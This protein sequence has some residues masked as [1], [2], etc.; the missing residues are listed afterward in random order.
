MP[1]A[2]VASDRDDRDY[3]SPLVGGRF[4]P[5]QPAR[6]AVHLGSYGPVQPRRR[7]T[8][9]TGVVTADVV[10]QPQD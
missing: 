7:V 2:Q 4:C 5:L 6:L 8:A 3:S 9:T 10:F 1:A